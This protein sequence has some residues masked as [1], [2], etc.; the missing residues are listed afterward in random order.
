MK[1]DLLYFRLRFHPSIAAEST[2][3]AHYHPERNHQGMI[4]LRLVGAA[5]DARYSI[6]HADIK[7]GSRLGG[8]LRYFHR[9]AA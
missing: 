5:N 7:C 6:N 9:E 2:Y 3:T 1:P 8:M 4:N